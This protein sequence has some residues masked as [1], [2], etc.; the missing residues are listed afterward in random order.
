MSSIRGHDGLHRL[1]R[2]A[3]PGRF[4]LLLDH[5][6]RQA[7]LFESR[8]NRIDAIARAGLDV[9]QRTPLYRHLAGAG[10]AVID[11]VADGAP[12]TLKRALVPPVGRR[13]RSRIISRRV[14]QT[15]ASC[16]W[17]TAIATGATV[18][19]RRDHEYILAGLDTPA[20]T[21]TAWI[22]ALSR[23]RRFLLR[24][25][26]AVLDVA[27]AIDAIVRQNRPGDH[28]NPQ[29]WT[30]ANIASRHSLRQIVMRASTTVYERTLP[31]SPQGPSPC[32][33]QAAL[34]LMRRADLLINDYLP[35]LGRADGEP[36]TTVTISDPVLTATIE[37]DMQGRGRQHGAIHLSADDWLDACGEASTRLAAGMGD[38]PLAFAAV[39]HIARQWRSPV[40]LQRQ[41]DRRATLSRRLTVAMTAITIATIALTVARMIAVRDEIDRLALDNHERRAAIADMHRMQDRLP[42]LTPAEQ[43][44]AD[45]LH[46]A[47]AILRAVL[48]QERDPTP[49]MAAVAKANPARD[50][51]PIR[52]DGWHWQQVEERLTLSLRLET[53]SRFAAQAHL[54]RFVERLRAMLPDHVVAGDDL[55]RRSRRKPRAPSR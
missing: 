44:L 29:R 16:L 15:L 28:S 48:R 3:V 36:I 43:A 41:E 1:L 32:D 33:P 9:D 51:S 34:D 18:G 40:K 8:G 54:A 19:P 10:P 23:H 11:I 25:R 45:D 47:A 50:N 7:H 21:V 26:I 2:T 24:P 35:R 55:P 12:A 20:S 38:N 52:V 22:S 42:T 39:I 53:G 46:D 27:P 6:G 14:R 30:V 49:V 13:D 5:E 17:T 37:A 31:L 4:V